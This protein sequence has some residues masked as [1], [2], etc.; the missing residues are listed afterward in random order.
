MLAAMAPPAAEAGASEASTDTAEAEATDAATETVDAGPADIVDTAVAAGSFRTLVSAVQERGLEETLRGEGPFTVFAP[1]DAAFQAL[2]LSDRLG[3]YREPEA[4]T[5][6]LLNHVVEGNLLSSDLADGDILTSV[7]G[8]E[9]TVTIDENGVFVNGVRVANPDVETT[10]GVIHILEGVIL[11]AADEAGEDAGSD[12]ADEA[13]AEETAATES[14]EV[15]ATEATT[16]TVEAEAAAEMTETVEAEATEAMTETEMTETESTEAAGDMAAMADIVD[17]AV[18]AGSFNT[19]VAAVQAAGLV[20]ALKGEG[21]FTVFAP[22]DDA[23]AAIPQE[24]IDALLADPSGDL[25]QILLYHVVPGKV[26]AADLSEGL[27]AATLQGGE[28]TFTLEDGAK[29]N[30]VNIVTTDIETSNGVIHVIDAVLLPGGGEEAA[31]EA[32]VESTDAAGDAAGGEAAA[33]STEATPE[34]LP[35][36]GA[37]ATGLPS[38]LAAMAVIALLVVAGWVSRRHMA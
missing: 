18:G 29:V 1:S 17:T 10:N 24:T 19:L 20:D 4:L 33:E 2:P 16:E 15:A 5:N 7:G 36:T 8:Q 11:P 22:T 9:L 13:A 12:A 31:E 37:A 21:P 32:A 14:T 34:A 23:F 30:G 35:A 28:L 6:V 3:L 26:M 38:M 27:T 25:T